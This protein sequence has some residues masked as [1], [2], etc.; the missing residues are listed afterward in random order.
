MRT[1]FSREHPAFSSEAIGVLVCAF[2]DAW[3]VVRRG[4]GITKA[5][6]EAKR[7][8]LARLVVV[9]AK[10]GVLD[11]EWLRDSALRHFG[12]DAMHLD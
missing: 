4:A 10:P 5:N 3:A 6:R 9:L 7:L 1:F 8:K 12:A 2:N 11:R